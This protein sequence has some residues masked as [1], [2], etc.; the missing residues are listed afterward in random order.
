MRRIF[1]WIGLFSLFTGVAGAETHDY[2][3]SF[4]AGEFVANKIEFEVSHP[5]RLRIEAQWAGARVVSFRLNGPGDGGST[6][7]LSGPSPQRLELDV[8]AAAAADRRPW[9]LSIRSLPARVGSQGTL[10]LFLPDPEG[11]PVALVEP[12]PGPPPP[13]EEYWRVAGATPA[14]TAPAQ[15][16]FHAKVE[17][18]RTV[19]VGEDYLIRDKYLWQD[20][21]L[22]FLVDRRNASDEGEPLPL[23]ESTR[24]YLE[25]IVDAVAKIDSLRTTD[26][27]ILKGRRPKDPDQRRRWHRER[28]QRLAP[29]ESELDL[30]LEDLRTGHAPELERVEWSRRLV[31]CLIACQRYFSRVGDDAEGYRAVGETQWKPVVAGTRAIEAL[32]ARP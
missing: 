25:R 7:R 4:P 8:D 22:R 26:D 31:S 10:K 13:P 14:R 12:E 28:R 11:E 30:L 19:V 9:T 21:L 2:S 15:A 17:S 20:E 6:L 27:P 18:F 29:L 1:L 32:L 24:A 23:S 5:G 3:L 16:R